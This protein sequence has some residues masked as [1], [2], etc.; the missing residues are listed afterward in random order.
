VNYRVEW[1][2]AIEP[3]LNCQR[4]VEPFRDIADRHFVRERPV[5]ARVEETGI[6]SAADERRPPGIE[7]RRTRGVTVDQND[8]FGCHYL[9]PGRA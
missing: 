3:R 2:I 7:G 5:A 4:A 6:I 9:S 8:W 1:L